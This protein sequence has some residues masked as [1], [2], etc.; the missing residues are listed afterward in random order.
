MLMEKKLVQPL[1]VQQFCTKQKKVTS[2]LQGKTKGL[3]IFLM[4]VGVMAHV[5]GNHNTD[6]KKN[7]RFITPLF[8]AVEREL[9]MSCH[10]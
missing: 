7:S 2:L 3:F 4:R 9:S 6:T 1:L 8:L 10:Q 5:A